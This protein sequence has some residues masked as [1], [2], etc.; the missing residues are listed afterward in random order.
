[1][2][3]NGIKYIGE[4]MKSE[5]LVFKPRASLLLQLGD[6][7]IKNENI[8]IVELIK[9][10]YDA[11]ASI[12]RVDL[13]D[14][15]SPMGKIVIEDD[16]YGMTADIVKNVWLEPGDNHKKEDVRINKISKKGRLPIGEKGI[17]RFGVHKL[18][19]QI[20][21][22]TRSSNNKEICVNIDWNKFE[23]AKYLEDVSIEIIEQEPKHFID[24]EG[25][26][27]EITGLKKI[28]NEKEFIELKRAI[29]HF[30]SPFKLQEDFK[31]ILN[32]NLEGWDKKVLTFEEI[33]EFALYYYK[34]I[35]DVKGYE[36]FSYK[37][38]PFKNMDSR[39]RTIN[40]SRL[41]T[42]KNG[43]PIRKR[44]KGIGVIDFELYCF[45][46]DN[47]I[48]SKFLTADKK[49][50]TQY[51][52]ANG[53]IYVFRDG[54]RI[55]DYGEAEN[56]WLELDHARFNQPAAKISNNIVIGA[57]NIKRNESTD[58]IEKSNREGFIENDAYKE[59]KNIIKSSIDNFL[60][61]RNADKDYLRK[62]KKEKKE[63]VV[64]D[65]K[66]LKIKIDLSEINTKDKKDMLAC[67]DRIESDY[68]RVKEVSLLTSTAGMSYGIVIHE[69][70]KIIKEISLRVISE[71]T[72]LEFKNTIYHL[73][74]IIQN[75]S[76]LIRQK[77]QENCSLLEIIKQAKF[78]C[79]YRLKAHN[80]KMIINENFDKNVKCSYN[81]IVGAI[82]NIIDNSIWWLHKYKV[83]DKKIYVCV[84]EYK[85]NYVSIVIADN[86]NGF[87]ID[88]ADAIKPFVTQK[89]GGIGLG[90]NIV[91][92]VMISHN[93]LLEFPEASEIAEMPKEFEK[94]AIV[95][96]N[97][98]EDI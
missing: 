2:C 6:Q 95:T 20:K 37:F 57:V 25:T 80:I 66:Q 42:D 19:S 90:L 49:Q 91:N 35:I 50:F 33:K 9:N 23:N 41:M 39:E 81:L 65:I 60:S 61:Y 93:G 11:D 17:G 98:K 10:S 54:T 83:E 75:Y 76:N 85:T 59:F 63:P 4:Y 46:R 28:W 97:F 64:D 21:L 22:I 62:G 51:L 55:Y 7:L 29:E 16:G 92:E 67:L 52:D 77:K 44:E 73:S 72:S 69:I 89:N 27:I 47:K 5:N 31:V 56:D 15:N 94:G 58:L 34:S 38:T 68:S 48:L 40:K 84:T 8:A 87:T 13:F 79:G 96:L 53:G 88:P 43:D 18:G 1:M 86:G 71:N 30:N 45:D 82:L 36:T 26:Y 12:V 78:N 70:E 32:T 74:E 24:K 3:Y 14:I